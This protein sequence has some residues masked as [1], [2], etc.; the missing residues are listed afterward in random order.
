[1]QSSGGSDYQ[2]TPA[3]REDRISQLRIF[4]GTYAHTPYF[5]RAWDEILALRAQQLNEQRE[6]ERAS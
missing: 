6:Q 2:K 3:L 5:A 1:M 4:A